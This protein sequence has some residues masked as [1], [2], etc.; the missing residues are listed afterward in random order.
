MRINSKQMK[1]MICA[2]FAIAISGAALAQNAGETA[3]EGIDDRFAIASEHYGEGKV[4]IQ[5]RTKID[6]KDAYSVHE[7]DC[8]EGKMRAFFENTD[9]ASPLPT[10]DNIPG[11]VPF[12]R[13]PGLGPLARHACEQHGFNLVEW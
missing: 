4:Q 12:E 10:S 13:T 6:D 5:S 3:I 2:C 11:D 8:V 7:V 1:P 9:E